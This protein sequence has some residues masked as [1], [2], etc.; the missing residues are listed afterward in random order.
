[1]NIASATQTL[2]QDSRH[3]LRLLRKNPGF[4]LVAVLTLALGIGANTAMFSIVHA[5]LLAPLP[6]HQPDRLLIV[7]ETN[8]RFP[9]VWVSYPNFQDWQRSTHSFQQMAAFLNQGADL[10]APGAPEHLD[11][12]AISSNFFRTL[13]V[14][15]LFGR[16]FSPQEDQR[17]GNPVAILGERLWRDRF[18]A[19]PDVLGQTITLDGVNHTIIGVVTAALTFGPHPA[20][21]YTPLGQGDP[22]LLNDR[23]AHVG[24]FCIARLAPAATMAQGQAEMSTAQNRLDALYPEANRDLGTFIEPLK[25]VLLQDL[26]KTLLLL[27]GAVGLVLLITCANVANLL[28]SRSAARTREFAVRTA[29]GASPSRLLR[30]LLTES[31]LLSLL[32][33]GLGVLLA[34]GVLRL[35]PAAFPTMLPPGMDVRIN[36]PVLLFTLL[37]SVGVGV[38][39][40]LAPALKSRNRDLQV[41]LKAGGRGSTASHHRAQSALVMAQMALTLV[42]LVGAGLLFRTLHHLLTVDPGFDTEHIITFRVGVSPSLMKTAANARS[43]FQQLI[44]QIRG[45]PGVQAAEFTDD[46]PLSGQGGTMPFWL[47]S[48]KPESLQAAPRIVMALTGPDYLRAMRIP[49]LRGRFFT[50]QDTVTSACVIVIDNVLA[51]NFFPHSDPLAETMSAGFSPVGPCRIV[52]VVGHVKQWH[53]DEPNSVPQNQAYFSL[54]QDPDRW[55]LVN[56]PYQT[57]VVRS[58][59]LGA[60]LMPAIKAAVHG[61]SSDQSLYA[62]QTMADIVSQSMSGQRFPMVLLTAFAG[63]A[64]LLASIGVYGVISYSVAQ[65]V[66]EIGVRLALGARQSSILKLIVGQGLRLAGLGLASGVIVALVLARLLSSFSNLLYGVSASDPPTFLAVATLLLAVAVLA[67]YIPAR[68]A[69]QVDPMVALRHE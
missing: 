29:L 53:M 54:Y 10:T 13:G 6:Y 15:P 47:N 23:A 59:L 67:S 36:A 7:W 57:I 40:G 18:A 64:L 12:Q 56:Y 41:A 20:D 69:T 9:R 3:G 43:A 58:P 65:R 32:G 26:G 1:M 44:Q 68:R 14:Q 31:V 33:G 45:I 42:L 4:A 63:L 30:Q 50:L 11:R 51:H 28:L 39:F 35:L 37:A 24:I 60:A 52:G 48:Q 21:L 16:E 8:P 25:Q 46:V 17:G 27:F 22:L 19:R 34:I 2:L 62:V 55:V 49:L 38:L 5:V 66:H 61:V